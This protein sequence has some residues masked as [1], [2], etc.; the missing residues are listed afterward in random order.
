MVGMMACE[1]LYSPCSLLR[2]DSVA[3]GSL[4]RDLLPVTKGTP[5]KAFRF[6]SLR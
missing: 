6:D 3:G 5:R 1:G 2:L 4:K